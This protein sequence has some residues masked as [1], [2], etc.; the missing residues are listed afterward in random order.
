[1]AEKIKFIPIHR[2]T[3]TM[4]IDKPLWGEMTTE[5]AIGE[6]QRE[7]ANATNITIC[8]VPHSFKC[9]HCHHPH[10]IGQARE[11]KCTNTDCVSNDPLH[12]PWERENELNNQLKLKYVIYSVNRELDVIPVK[13]RV[14]LIVRASRFYGGTE[15]K[16]YISPVLTSP[17]WEEIAVHA[18]AS[19]DVTK[20][21]HHVFLENVMPDTKVGADGVRGVLLC[22]GS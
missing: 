2:V 6:V 9:P 10:T 21:D 4:L 19:I 7:H 1:M 5:M 14:R 18:D 22:F 11:G 3:V 17:T 15:S 8:D 13:G 20:D 12:I 16:D